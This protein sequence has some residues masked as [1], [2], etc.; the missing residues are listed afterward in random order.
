MKHRKIIA[1]ALA[2]SIAAMS[3]ASCS[4]SDSSSSAQESSSSVRVTSKETDIDNTI[5]QLDLDFTAND[6]DVGYDA[7]SATVIV[8]EADTPTVTGEGAA[9]DGRNVTITSA[10]CYIVTGVQSDGQ[11]II[12]ADKEDKIQ[13]VLD[14]VTLNCNSGPAVYV[15][16]AEKVFITLADGTTNTLTDSGEEYAA[17]GDVSPDAVIFSKEDLTVNGTGKLVINAGYKHGIVSKDDLVFTG[18]DIEIT[19]ANTAIEGKDSVKIA[20]GTFKI[21]SGTNGIC[22]SNDEDTDKGYVYIAG[23]S[24]DIEAG[25]DGIQAET[26]LTVEDGEFNIVTGGGSANATKKTNDFGGKGGFGGGNF[27]MP[28][29]GE[30]PQ[31][32][33]GEKPDLNSGDIPEMPD[34]EKPDFNNGEMPEFKG[35][36][37]F[38][39]RMNR[40]EQPT[41]ETSDEGELADKLETAATDSTADNTEK[42]DTQLQ[43]DSKDADLT[44]SQSRK[45]L[46]AGNAIAILGGKFTVDSADDT[47]HSG[48]SVVISG[49]SLE[50]SSGDDGIHAD[51][52]VE[53]GSGTVNITKSYEGVEAKYITVNGG[54]VTVNASDDG[55]NAS[56]GSGESFGGFGGRSDQQSTDSA[57]TPYLKITNGKIYVNAN[58]DG[59][60]SNGSMTVEG[61]DVTVDGPTNGGNGALDKGDGNYQLTVTGG[62][63]AAFGATG[64]EEGFTDDSTQVSLLHNFTSTVA[65]GTE[66]TVKDESGSVIATYTPAKSWQS[67]VF[68]SDKLEQGKTY[69]ITAGDQSE[70][71]TLDKINTSNSTGGFGGFGGGMGGRQGG[72]NSQTT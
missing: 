35:G 51:E 28:Q 12:D 7:S 43:T 34:G 48:G 25:T 30:T 9:A 10:G 20:D 49:G 39:G 57:D 44:D 61:G 19:A 71:V 38:G 45:G 62:T 6:L 1:F 37:N 3:L 27:Q 72:R 58:G 40:G 65:A 50:L 59:L 14:D 52:T 31:M 13:L 54:S 23:G 33:D 36:G 21:K 24:F 8:Y 53:I 46:K 67:M 29:D 69:T 18:G 15:K 70:T 60:D 32:P 63:L 4:K 56:D 16:S 11:I 68:T 64:M 5:S 22:A 42:A 55:F 26:L 47:L 17:D 2:L 66:V 41:Q